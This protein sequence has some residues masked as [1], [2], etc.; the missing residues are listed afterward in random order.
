MNK[1]QQRLDPMPDARRHDDAQMLHRTSLGT[2]KHWMGWAHFLTGG[3]KNM[4][5]EMSLEAYAPSGPDQLPKG[6]ANHIGVLKRSR[7]ARANKA[8]PCAWRKSAPLELSHSLAEKQASFAE[9]SAGELA[10]SR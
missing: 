10:Y 1:I 4:A 5:P 7:V 2:L 8:A 6:L 3:I 9:A